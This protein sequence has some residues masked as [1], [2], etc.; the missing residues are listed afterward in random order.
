MKK[1]LDTVDA[2]LLKSLPN[3]G[4]GFEQQIDIPEFTFLGVAE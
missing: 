4:R 3:A 1:L 2:A